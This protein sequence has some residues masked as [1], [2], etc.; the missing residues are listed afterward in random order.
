MIFYL[1]FINLILRVDFFSLQ[2][3]NTRINLPN[4]IMTSHMY[5]GDGSRYLATTRMTWYLEDSVYQSHLTPVGER[6]QRET[7]YDPYSSGTHQR[8]SPP[9][10][11]RRNKPAPS[12]LRLSPV[13]VHNESLIN[14]IDRAIEKID[15]LEQLLPPMISNETEQPLIHT[16]NT[17]YFLN[18]ASFILQNHYLS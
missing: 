14:R 11:I 1:L 8:L 7:M 12:S 10:Q 2:L 16:K 3:T 5:H 17:T 15:E 6:I 18:N 9:R 13:P 4:I